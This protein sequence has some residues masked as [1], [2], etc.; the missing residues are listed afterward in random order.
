MFTAKS[1]NED[2]SYNSEKL[3]HLSVILTGLI[4]IRLL[5]EQ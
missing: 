2:E 3:S 1:D 4:S 5:L